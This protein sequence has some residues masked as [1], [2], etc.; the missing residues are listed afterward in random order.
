MTHYPCQ[1]SILRPRKLR[2]QGSGLWHLEIHSGL[3][4]WEIGIL[5]LRILARS[6]WVAVKELFLNLL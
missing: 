6:C 5:G 2:L 1:H 4:L 3:K